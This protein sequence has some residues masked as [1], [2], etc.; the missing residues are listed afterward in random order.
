[1]STE[2]NLLFFFSALGAFNG[3]LFGLYFLLLAKPVNRANKYLGAFLL[4]LSIRVG[5][6]VFF[7]FDHDLA[8]EYLQFGLTACLF[9]GPFLY[10][11]LGETARGTGA[12][13][14]P[15][16]PHLAP[17]LLLALTGG[18]LFPY[19]TY[20][21][22]WNPGFVLGIYAVWAGYSLLGLYAI[23]GPLAAV[24]R[25]RRSASR[26]D[27]WR[28]SLGLGSLLIVTLYTLVGFTHYL[29]G[30]IT[31]SLLLYGSWFYTFLLRDARTPNLPEPVTGRAPSASKRSSGRSL[32]DRE[33]QQLRRALERAERDDALIT[34]P[35]LKLVD[36]AAFAKTSPHAL[37]RYLNEHR[38]SSFAHFVGRARIERAKALVLA[39]DHLTLDAI[40]QQ[41][42]FNSRS[43]FY[44]AFK[45]ETGLTPAAWK[46]SA[47]GATPRA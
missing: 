36:L 46:R 11:Y 15:A 45:R 35:N 21:Q 12:K 18:T 4:A 26:H 30:A 27:V 28:V 13:P 34:D 42:G 31:F 32:T 33:S 9:I 2:S 8:R 23:R 1:M 6:S 22:L 16:W 14:P 40:G 44:A 7:Q 5:K 24:L 19:A 38:G 37:S 41:C 29:S 43:T 25:H 47:A 39:A 17:W 10:L 20:P 3:L